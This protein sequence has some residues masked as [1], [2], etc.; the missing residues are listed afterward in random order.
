VTRKY[1]ISSG[2][3]Y[4]WR[5]QVLG[6]QMGLPVQL[7]PSFARV[8]VTPAAGALDTPEPRVAE[9]VPAW[10]SVTPSCPESLIEIALPSGVTLRVDARV[11][12][13]AL[14]RVLPAL[15]HR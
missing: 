13:G 5:Q 14:R 11:D 15:E 4:T 8:E 10:T 12:D 7:A 6:G 1:A 3:L 2:Q 9:S